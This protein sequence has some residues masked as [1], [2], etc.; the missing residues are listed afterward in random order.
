[1]ALLVK[2]GAKLYASQNWDA[3]YM[4]DIPEDIEELSPAELSPE[5]TKHFRGL[6][7][8]LPLQLF[9]VAPFRAAL[10]EKI[11]LARYFHEKMQ[12]IEGFEVGPVPD[13]SVVTYR[14]LPKHG[15]VDTFNERLT[16]RVQ[17]EG[18]IFI[19]STRIGGK[20]VLRMAIS[21]FRT[22]LDHIDEALEVLQWNA[23][24]L[25]EQ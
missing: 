3:A 5:L 18:R 8:W 6:R 25:S 21:S 14:Y 17:E 13:L 12:L 10:S 1:V 2:D 24:R 20:F 11:Q 22:H 4:Q 19:S 23:G 9:G 15:D 7:V 16:K